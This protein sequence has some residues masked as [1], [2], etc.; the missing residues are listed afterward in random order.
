MTVP[1]DVLK[2]FIEGK[3]GLQEASGVAAQIASDPDLAAYVEDQKAFQAALASPSLAWLRRLRERIAGQSASWIPAMAMTGGIV[4]G[5]FLA[6][7]FGI[8]TDMRS[9]GGT[10]IAQGE[11]AHMLNTALASDSDAVPLDRARI[12]TSFWSKNGVFCRGFATQRNTQGA[13]MG[14]ACR[15]RGAWHIVVMAAVEAAEGAGTSSAL[16]VSVRAV[17]ENL[18]VGEPLKDEAERQAR[19]QGWR[20]Q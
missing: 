17:M 7:S 6:A 3:L 15:E 14:I 4:L 2:A 5:V 9:Q 1:P 12:G 20:P 11:L 18:I 16:P 19:S 10:L 8:A 13:L